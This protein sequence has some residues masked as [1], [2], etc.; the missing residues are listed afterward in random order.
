VVGGGYKYLQW[1]EGCCFLRLPPE[2]R[3]RP[4]LTGWFAE[5]AT[6]EEPP[7]PGGVAYGR[8]AERFAGSTYDPTA[9]YR[10]AAVLGHFREMGLTV[11]VLRRVSQHQV[12]GLLRR[13]QA[14]DPDPRILAVADPVPLEARGG[15]LSLRTPRARELV[16]AL[17]SRGVWVDAR[18]DL[19]RLGPAPYLGDGQL[20]E[21]MD[22][23]LEVALSP[24]GS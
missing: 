15:F 9:H 8:G 16:G 14:A 23:V 19:L 5:F 2:T 20:D 7:V 1:G 24:A 4:V 10:A 6:L 18:E 17:R 21:A 13:F 11:P 22:R 3:L 12:G